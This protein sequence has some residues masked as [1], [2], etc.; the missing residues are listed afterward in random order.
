MNAQQPLSPMTFAGQSR[1][2]PCMHTLRHTRSFVTLSVLLIFTIALTGCVTT[3]KGE[4]L[5]SQDLGRKTEKENSFVLSLDYSRDGLIDL[6]VEQEQTYKIQYTKKYREVRDRK[7]APW[8]LMTLGGLGTTINGAVIAPG[9]F[10]PE[11]ENEPDVPCE[12]EE[13]KA[14]VNRAL[15]WL[16][17]GGTA[18][19]TGLIGW[20]ASADSAGTATDDVVL[21]GTYS[22]TEDAP[23]ISA[24]GQTLSIRLNNRTKEYTTDSSGRIT[25]DPARD[26]G[27]QSVD[28]ARPLVANAV[29]PKFDFATSVTLDPAQWMQPKFRFTKAGYYVRARPYQG[30]NIVGQTTSDDVATEVKITHREGSWVKFQRPGNSDAWVNVGAGEIFWASPTYL[31]P[32]RLP[33]L[34]ATVDFSEQSGNRQLDA[35]ET[36]QAILRVQNEGQG[37]A[38][39]V[40]ARVRPSNMSN[41]SYNDL[42]DFGTIPAGE[43]KTQR[44]Q[45][46]A[47][48]NVPTKVT[49]LTFDFREA[50]GFEPS[51][52]NL[53]FKTREFH[54]P[55]LTV[56]EV[57]IQDA[58]MNGEIEPGEL[59]NVTARIKNQGDGVARSVRA[60][61]VLG[62]DV[63]EGPSFEANHQIGILSP[64]ET[65]D[66]TFE[67]Y[68]N[69]RADD[70]QVQLNLTESYGKFGVSGFDLDLPFNRPIGAISERVTPMSPETVS[71]SS[72]SSL[73][74]PIWKNLPR[75][76]TQNP[77]AVGIVIGV[78]D[79]ESSAVP[80]V[81]YAQRDAT[82]MRRYLTEVMGY[83]EENILPRVQDSDM[84]LGPMKTL[85]RSRLGDYLRSGS[86][87]FVFF[88]GHGAPST[89]EDR[90]AYLVPSDAD[91]NYVSDDNAYRLETFYEDLI[92]AMDE[93]DAG[94]LT[95]VLDACF[96][97]Q[98]GGGEMMI[99]QA[100]PLTLTVE[101]PISVRDATTVFAASENDQVANWYPDMQH[102]MF[103]YFFLKGLKG[104][105][106]LD[107]DGKVTVAEMKKYLTD[108]DDG[109]PHHSQRIHSRR[110]TPDVQTTEED[111]VLVEY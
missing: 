20:A 68:T 50:N 90:A 81:E 107:G 39:R 83:S 23:S 86:D 69:Q 88:S 56:S 25:I 22:R 58:S 101:S 92:R 4:Y 111:R 102:G 74:P 67:M 5:G 46:E 98:S 31:D 70:V 87:V 14:A 7:V 57:G 65:S 91:P 32:N 47:D 30:S 29:M 97:G 105:G 79:Y 10:G 61:I 62:S 66:I 17:G 3:K 106:D 103:T 89:G 44:V 26:F 35:D 49:N 16:I 108:P 82:I 80:D 18:I 12:S 84:T 41:L 96:T 53:E 72:P 42:V 76:E 37:T 75:A 77:D 6:V 78:K 34:V 52:I 21:D 2:P 110:Q 40:R 63:F 24:A 51:P 95:V 55:Q 73:T 45:I 85:I 93:N 27:L 28:R 60:R 109:V 54:P 94:S 71:G 99:R 100:S 104:D 36:A 9:C 11:A 33:R 8:V 59:V 1:T 15:P 64:G 48:L 43:S 38:Y 19:L 13:E